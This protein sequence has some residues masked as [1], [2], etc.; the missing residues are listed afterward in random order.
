MYSM[1]YVTGDYCSSFEQNF[2][3]IVGTWI[4]LSMYFLDHFKS[5]AMG[6]SCRI[7]CL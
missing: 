6:F 1:Q 3:S 5:G 4:R 2:S 7:C